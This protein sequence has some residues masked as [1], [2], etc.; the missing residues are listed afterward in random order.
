MLGEERQPASQRE[1]SR[2]TPAAVLPIKLDPTNPG[3]FLEVLLRTREAWLEVS[4]NDG[5]KEVRRWDAHE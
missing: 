2:A 5:Q 3:D 1:F 4:Y